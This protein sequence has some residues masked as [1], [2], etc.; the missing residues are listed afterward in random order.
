MLGGLGPCGRE[1]CCVSFLGEFAPVSIKMAKE[2]NLSLNPT[3]ISGLCGRLMC[4]L[5]FESEHYVDS[6]ASLPEPGTMVTTAQGDGKVVSVN[7]LKNTA[8]V[9][10]DN[11]KI[12]EVRAEEIE[13]PG[14]QEPACDCPVCPV[15]QAVRETRD[16]QAPDAQ[17]DD[18][19]A[20]P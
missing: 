14:V 15:A 5:R 12:V 20:G 1:I 10:L 7:V 11:K 8:S 9:E 19:E 6:R 2:Q 13:H 3:K 4:C 18:G 17:D 16:A